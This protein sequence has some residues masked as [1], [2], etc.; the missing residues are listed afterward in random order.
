MLAYTIHEIISFN[1]TLNAF[2]YNGWTVEIISNKAE[3]CTFSSF[4]FPSYYG[5]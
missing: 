1:K 4:L 2:Y 5:Y 3:V